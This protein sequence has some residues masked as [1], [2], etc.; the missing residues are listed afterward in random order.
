MLSA[1]NGLNPAAPAP[2]AKQLRCGRA[3]ARANPRVETTLIPTLRPHA[4]D[5]C[6]ATHRALP[7]CPPSNADNILRLLIRHRNREPQ[8]HA[9]PSDRRITTC[10]RLAGVRRTGGQRQS[11]RGAISASVRGAISARVPASPPSRATRDQHN[12]P[13]THSTPHA[14]HPSAH[15]TMHAPRH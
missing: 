14:Q 6:R 13:A 11:V 7:A 8:D 10:H 3:R 1:V 5:R 9:A 4:C 15:I 12:S 2:S